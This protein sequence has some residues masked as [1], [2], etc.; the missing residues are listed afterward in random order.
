M[1][2]RRLAPL[3]ALALVAAT[4]A[5]AGA[6][7]TGADEPGMVLLE[8]AVAAARDVPHHGRLLVASFSREGPQLTE[9]HVTR[10]VDGGMTVTKEDGWEVGRVGEEAFLRSSGTLLRL[11]G[12]ERGSTVDLERLGAKYAVTVDAEPTML[13]TGPARVLRVQERAGER[14]REVLYLD[15]ETDLIV[16]RETFDTD[17]EP[18]RVV[19]YTSLE[20]VDARVV[21]PDPDGLEV[22][23]FSLAPADLAAF[24][25][26]GFVAPE[27]LPAGYRLLGGFERSEASVPTLHLVYGD[28]LYTLSVFEQ[29]GRLAQQAL[30]GAA[31][32]RAPDGVTVWR[33]PGSEPR[34]VI[35]R[36]GDRTYTAITDA[37]VDELLAV[38]TGLPNDPAPSMLGRLTRGIGRVGR[39]LWPLDRSD[40]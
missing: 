27:E 35:W 37:P 29:Q 10:G 39:W 23:A 34:R 28:G 11:G 12:M 1:R 33:L 32:L 31:L 8:R 40:T 3:V 21:A 16:R 19:A 38:V 4:S 14:D 15:A 24:R 6:T 18:L 30:D 7:V 17:G 25:D 20:V 2:I 36:G 26:L 5:E 13:D 9:V 22:E